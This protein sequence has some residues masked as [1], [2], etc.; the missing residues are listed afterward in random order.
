MKGARLE[1]RT[2][3]IS[4]LEQH[5]NDLIQSIEDAGVEVLDVMASPIAAS[6]VTLTRAQKKAGC[7]LA[8]I[9]AETVSIAVFENNIPISLQVFPIGSTDITNDIALGLKIHLEDAE[10]IKH[11]ALTGVSYERKQLDDIIRARLSDIFELIEAHLKKLGRSALLPAG[12]VITGGG[13]GITSIEDIARAML[14]LPSRIAVPNVGGT[15]HGE[16]DDPS[17]SVAYGLCVWGSSADQGESTGI[18]LAKKA[19]SKVAAWLRQFL[20]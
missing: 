13:S 7:V 6:F 11:G 20:P 19:R 18:Q 9:G 1:V 2:L 3:F 5:L 15:T 14:A 12:I 10:D 17:W 8:N 16:L 4:T